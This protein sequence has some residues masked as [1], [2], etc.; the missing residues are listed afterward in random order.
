MDAQHATE[1]TL[2]DSL[3]LLAYL[4]E[5]GFSAH[6]LCVVLAQAAVELRRRFKQLELD[7]QVKH[8][9]IGNLTAA[10][11]AAFGE[12]M[13]LLAR[14]AVEMQTESLAAAELSESAENAM[15]DAY[16]PIQTATADAGLRVPSA[17]I[18]NQG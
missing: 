2:D 8:N 16:K 6:D 5:Q 7:L 13:D 14:M 9:V 11:M 15:F 18:H 3:D 10:A 17:R 4:T 1:V 12:S